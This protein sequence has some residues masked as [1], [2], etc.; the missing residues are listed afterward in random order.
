VHP[1]TVL[2]IAAAV[3]VAAVLAALAAAP[4][5]A[6]AEGGAAALAWGENTASQLG[7]GWRDNWEEAPVGVLGLSNV[8]AIAAGYH[9]SLALLADGTVRAWGGNDFYQLGNGSHE[10]SATPAPVLGLSGVRA[11]SAAGMHDLALLADGRVMAWGNND[12]G[13]LGNGLLNP[14]RREVSEGVFEQT[15][16]GTGAPVPVEVPGLSN[17][18]AVASGDGSNYVLLANGTMMAWGRNDHGQLGIGEIGPEVCNAEVGQVP[19]STKPRPV[20]LTATRRLGGV[21]AISAGG[22]AGY[23]LRE[24]GTVMAWGNNGSGQLGTGD[25][26]SASF[27]APVR[28]LGAGGLVELTGVVA[29][30]GGQAHALA[31]LGDGQVVG[32][33]GNVSGQL[34]LASGEMCRKTPCKMAAQTIG[35][36]RKIAAISAGY[37]FS[38]A[39]NQTGTVYA[40]G[41][42]TYGKLGD[43]STSDSD[44]PIAIEGIGPVNAIAAGEQSS[45]ALLQSGPAPAPLVSLA[46]QVEALKLTWTYAAAEYKLRYTPLGEH[47]FS[48]TVTLDEGDPRSYVFSGLSVRPYEVVI[49]SGEKSRILL[50]TPQP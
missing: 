50:G 46:A 11:I 39:L 25:T 9:F 41:D 2:P 32:W 5:S 6:R 7:A 37:R 49:R 45:L 1:R 8:T 21:Q 23:A 48:P 16:V 4:A 47:Q 13:Q 40:L 42:N 20:L 18:T 26:T 31:L 43:G 29:V 44:V 35:G 17:V 36:L 15:M 24:G 33:G 30:D 19:C 12:Y 10:R 14:R 38:L 22:E 28:R 34:G 3:V 27:A